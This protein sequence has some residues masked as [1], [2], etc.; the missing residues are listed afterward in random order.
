LKKKDQG[1]KYPQPVALI[2]QNQCKQHMIRLGYR[3]LVHPVASVDA[4]NIHN[5]ELP[6]TFR[7][8]LMLLRSIG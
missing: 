2:N 3:G 8:L 6:I 7:K 1:L 4:S 5:A